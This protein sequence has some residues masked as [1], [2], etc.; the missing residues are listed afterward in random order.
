MIFMKSRRIESPGKDAFRIIGIRLFGPFE[1][2]N[3]KE[4]HIMIPDTRGRLYDIYCSLL[5]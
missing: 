3:E 5:L 1:F 2:S 4:Y